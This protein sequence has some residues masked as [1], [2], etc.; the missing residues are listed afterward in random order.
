MTTGS[1]TDYWRPVYHFTA[2]NEWI[3][4]PNGLVYHDGIYHLF[5]QAGRYRRRWDHAT[6]TDLTDWKLHGT[7]IADTPSI[8]AF[9]GGA[10]VDHTNTAGFGENALV[11]MYTG[12]HNDG[13]EDQRIAYSTDG[14]ATVTKYDGNPI[15]ESSVGDFRD[16]KPFWYSPD[17]SWRM[18]VGRIQGTN[19][20]RPGMEIYSSDDL[21]DWTYE[22]T[23][24]DADNEKW[25][26]PNLIQLPVSESTET[27]WMTIVS[28]IE[29]RFVEYHIGHFDGTEFIVEDV[30]Q[31]DHGHDFYATQFWENTP[32]MRGLNIS[33]MNNWAYA[34]N[35]SD[36][37]WHGSMTVPRTL[38]LTETETGIEVRQHPVSD[39]TEEHQKTVVEIPLTTVTSTAGPLLRTDVVGATPEIVTTIELK[40]ADVVGFRL[41]DGEQCQC[42][43]K[44][45]SCSEKLVFNRMDPDTTFNSEE[46]GCTSMPV[47]P[48]T[49]GT[50]QLRILID[51]CSVEIFANDGYRSMTN[52]VHSDL[53]KT[54][55]GFFAE[56][57]TA[58]I[59][60]LVVYDLCK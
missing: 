12:H 5:Y 6:S 55:V 34:E 27:K 20:R 32:E 26:C 2:D 30:I 8:Q 25:E 39:V 3:N 4:D 41:Q 42:A 23:Y 35:L 31:A 37:G 7:K 59:R 54:D 10:V 13:T 60:D 21:I 50:I 44:Y 57:G 18:V 38:E 46:Y 24:I 43:I 45:N 14:G 17:E 52:L 48:R 51:Q 19:D 15:I 29:N 49:D 9:S 16:P 11:C 22:S 47:E 1:K 40:D 53:K 56:G 28:P 36:R 33:W 58:K